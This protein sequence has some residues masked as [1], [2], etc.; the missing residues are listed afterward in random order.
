M[1]GVFTPA[2]TMPDENRAIVPCRDSA[3]GS[4]VDLATGY[5]RAAKLVD[6]IAWKM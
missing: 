4:S 5:P 2:L 6:L 1:G 3:T